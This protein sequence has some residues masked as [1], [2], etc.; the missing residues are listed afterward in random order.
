MTATPE[1]RRRR[2]E[3]GFTLAELLAAVVIVALLAAISIP[4]FTTGKARAN[5]GN[6]RSDGISVA[7]AIASV[8][9]D[10]TST[11]AA[12]SISNAAPNGSMSLGGVTVS[13]RLTSGSSVDAST[14]VLTT[15]TAPTWCLSMVNNGQYVRYTEAGLAYSGSS[16]TAGSGTCA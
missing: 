2:S 3:A 9:L 4:V 16:A 14:K 5:L 12:S 13:Y 1:G 8:A 10:F 15:G 7:L 11:G 6:A